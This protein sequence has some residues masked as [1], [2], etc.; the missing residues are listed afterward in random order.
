MA[1]ACSSST[2]MASMVALLLVW[3]ATVQASVHRTTVRTTETVT[4]DRPDDMVEYGRDQ[5]SGSSACR[6]E[7]MDL[8]E[9]KSYVEHG[10]QGIPLLGF[11]NGGSSQR[12]PRRCCQQ[13]SETRQECRCQAI[14][15]LVSGSSQRRAEDMEERDDERMKKRAENLPRTCGLSHH[16]CSIPQVGTRSSV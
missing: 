5:W 4:F 10:R 2:Q 12:P 9:C 14:R 15:Q 13:L 8:E 16:H 3:L 7:Q 11:R 1:M 6:M